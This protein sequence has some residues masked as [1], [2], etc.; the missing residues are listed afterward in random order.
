M[1]N[2]FFSFS[3]YKFLLLGIQPTMKL[4]THTI[5]HIRIAE[6]EIKIISHVI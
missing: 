5:N 6:K 1:T 3:Y 4:A 2:Q